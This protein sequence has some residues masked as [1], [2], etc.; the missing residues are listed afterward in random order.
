MRPL[1]L[2]LLFQGALIQAEK[3][4]VTGV[5]RLADGK[6]AVGVRVAAM[7]TPQSGTDSV[8]ATALISLTKTDESGRYRLE[9]VEPGRYYIIAGR[10][11]VP[12]YYPGVT[13]AAN[14]T[15]ITI[16]ASGTLLGN[17]DFIVAEDSTKPLPS[18]FPAFPSLASTQLTG[19]ILLDD[20]SKGSPLPETVTLTFTTTLTTANGT[21]ARLSGFFVTTAVRPDGGFQMSGPGGQSSISLARLPAGYSAKSITAGS[22]DLLTQPL[23][24]PPGTTTAPEI[25][26][27]LAVDSPQRQD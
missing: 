10:V 20:N 18:P 27:I 21:R 11:D 23:D 4:S 26:I 17:V 22:T 14:A 13:S 9:G 16:T 2:L 19:R 3:A 7:A 6:P 25:V 5:V 12:T 1:L 15:S 24:I 8:N